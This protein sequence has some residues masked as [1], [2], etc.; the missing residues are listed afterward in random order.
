MAT[1]CFGQS[2]AKT[3]ELG[4]I[5]AADAARPG[6]PPLARPEQPGA[7]PLQTPEENAAASEAAP[8]IPTPVGEPAGAATS[9]APVED[10]GLPLEQMR[11]AIEDGLVM[12]FGPENDPVP[13]YAFAAWEPLLV[14]LPADFV[15]IESDGPVTVPIGWEL[16]REGRYGGTWVGFATLAA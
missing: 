5:A 15:V 10:A 8:S 16:V 11:L 1:T 14:A 7:A 13:P 2:G 9:G 3:P 6:A 12:V 4:T